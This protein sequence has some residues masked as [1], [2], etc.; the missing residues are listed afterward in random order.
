MHCNI[1]IVFY[2]ILEKGFK[3]IKAKY[4]AESQTFLDPVL[5]KPESWCKAKF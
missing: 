1:F 2:A 4:K 5:A 3:N